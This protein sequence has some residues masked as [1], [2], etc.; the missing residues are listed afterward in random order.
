M[1]E[2]QE[3]LED[4]VADTGGRGLVRALRWALGPLGFAST[5]ARTTPLEA[6]LSRPRTPPPPAAA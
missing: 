1:T 4:C 3:A 5:K 2:Y 6:A